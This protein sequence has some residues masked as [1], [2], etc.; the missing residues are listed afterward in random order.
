MNVNTR[1]AD[2]FF[3][4]WPAPMYQLAQ[5][6]Q[7]TN[8]EHDVIFA[9][10]A[11]VNEGA[12]DGA[13][14]AIVTD[15]GGRVAP[16]PREIYVKPRQEMIYVRGTDAAVLFHPGSGQALLAGVLERKRPVGVLTMQS[17]MRR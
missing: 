10:D 17:T 13:G 3:N 6:T 16:F 7:I 1:V 12:E 15:L 11:P 14:A 4:E 5:M 9:L 8:I 2:T